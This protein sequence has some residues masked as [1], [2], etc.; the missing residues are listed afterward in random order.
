MEPAF[1]MRDPSYHAGRSLE[2]EPFL[3]IIESPSLTVE[4]S[5]AGELAR[6]SVGTEALPSRIGRRRSAIVIA[7]PPSPSWW[8]GER[9]A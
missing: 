7:T 1:G 6:G 8:R 9:R 3:G 5:G 2:K 4:S